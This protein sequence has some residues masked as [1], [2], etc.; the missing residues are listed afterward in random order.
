MTREELKKLYN[1]KREKLD[2]KSLKLTAGFKAIT[3]E[4][5][6]H[7]FSKDHFNLGCHYCGT[8]NEQSLRLYNM[9]RS[10]IR[11]DATRGG[12]RGKRLELDRKNPFKPYD[13]LDNIVW[14][15][16]WC[17]NAKSNF[18]TYEE[19]KPIALAIGETLKSI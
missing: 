7:W 17:N 1:Q 5:F 9:Q 6:N 12:K 16:Y 4:E 3:F 8:T 18:F 19:F 15:C 10:G 14:S 2:K 11:P 13:D